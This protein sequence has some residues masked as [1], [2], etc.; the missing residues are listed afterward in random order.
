MNLRLKSYVVAITG[1]LSLCASFSSSAGVVFSDDFESGVLGPAWSTSSTASG[2]ILVSNVLGTPANSGNFHLA[3]DSEVNG[4]PSLNEA[5]LTVDLSGLSNVMLSFFHKDV[6]DEDHPL[7]SAFSG[8]FDGDGVSLSVDGTNWF[9]LTN[10][11]SAVSPNNV[12][13]ELF[14]DLSTVAANNGLVLSNSTQIKFQQFDNFSIPTDG[15]VFDDIVISANVPEPASLLLLG[16]GL[17]GLGFARRRLH[18]SR[19]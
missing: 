18:Q 1:L 19:A 15:R 2:R 12:Y 4:I 6:N 7:P 11:T 5:V 3:M 13:T 17:A 16:A 10:L 9:L 8:S 14:A